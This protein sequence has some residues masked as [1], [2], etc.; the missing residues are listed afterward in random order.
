MTTLFLITTIMFLGNCGGGMKVTV[1]PFT[2]T[3]DEF[4]AVKAT[5]LTAGGVADIG[6]GRSKR[7]DLAKT[8][9]RAKGTAN[10]AAIYEANVQSL[11]KKFQEE[12][13]E[14][15]DT[16][17]NEAF[18]QAIKITT[19]KKLNFAMPKKTKY[20]QEDVDGT[21][22]YTC[23]ILMAI[24]PG[25]LNQSLM[26]ELKNK[27]EKTYERFRASEAYDEL[28]KAMQDYEAPDENK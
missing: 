9:A 17:I 20:L 14:D 10:L 11:T 26:D 25:V 24:E 21:T 15:A 5:I 8:S 19:Q 16:E 23:Y 1:D 12:L 27:N 2:E 6:I 18:S 22:M 13:G 7:R 3:E 4:E 28:D